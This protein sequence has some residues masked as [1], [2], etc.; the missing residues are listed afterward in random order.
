[1]KLIS[2]ETQKLIILMC[3]D[4]D[5]FMTIPVFTS[6]GKISHKGKYEEIVISLKN[7]DNKVDLSEYI[8][9]ICPFIY[10]DWTELFIEGNYV[11]L[12]EA[13]AETVKQLISIEGT[14]K[15]T[16]EVKETDN[17]NKNN[18]GRVY[19]MPELTE[20][21]KAAY[22]DKQKELQEQ[23]YQNIQAEFETM[24]DSPKELELAITKI[25]RTSPNFS[26]TNRIAL[27]HQGIY[28]SLMTR[29][30]WK[31]LGFAPKGETALTSVSIINGDFIGSEG[32]Q[33]PSFKQKAVYGTEAFASP[34]SASMA[35]DE[36]RKKSSLTGYNPT[37]RKESYMRAVHSLKKDNPDMVARTVEFQVAS[38]LLRKDNKILRHNTQ[39]RLDKDT[40]I[41]IRND[42]D[43][44]NFIDN[45]SNMYRK[46]DTKVRQVAF[47]RSQQ[48]A[49]ELAYSTEIY[50]TKGLTDK[51]DEGFT[52]N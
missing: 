30:G 38:Y 36:Y 39:F 19:V 44:R 4:I 5:R 41:H 37:I 50:N 27:A 18:D 29:D 7:I 9:S 2:S 13:P 10:K 31:K 1:M 21:Q 12:H 15:E 20:K 28:D 33:Y 34:A 3:A 17:L 32:K 6:I 51:E 35:F 52:L 26:L 25:G 42:K 43:R 11:G 24:F 48:L 47:A 8:F 49:K 22:R 23:Y 46:I 14:P 45:V 16:I 40:Q